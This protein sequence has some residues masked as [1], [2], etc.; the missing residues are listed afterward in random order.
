MNLERMAAIRAHAG[1][2]W[3]NARGRFARIPA[4]ARV[5]LGFFL[6]AALMMALHAGFSGKDASLRLKV[7]H[8]LRSGQLSVWVDG[9]LAYSGSLVGK[10]K[11]GLIPGMQGSLSETLPIRPGA[12]RIKVQVASDSGEREN[13]ISGEFAHNRQETLSVS[14]SRA[15]LSL[16][17]Q[18]LNGQ[19]TETGGIGS[20]S[21]N[22]WLSRYAGT[23]MMTIA[24]S[25]ISALTGFALKELPKQIVSRQGEA[26]KAQANQPSAG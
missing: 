1:M 25:I 15:D 14:A 6:I 5:M 7:Q 21:N 19:F 2:V 13:T 11:F 18:S 24:G 10:R 9:D 20:P 22:G 8:S 16:S 3:Q 23:F 4:T 12:H 26:S 17:W